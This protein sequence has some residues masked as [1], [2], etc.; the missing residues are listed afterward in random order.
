M[1]SLRRAE[2]NRFETMRQLTSLLVKGGASA[3]PSTL[4]V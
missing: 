1:A 2:A 4:T 3:F